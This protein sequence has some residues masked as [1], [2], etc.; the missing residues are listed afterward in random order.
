MSCLKRV[1]SIKHCSWKQDNT[2]SAVGG[3]RKLSWN[4]QKYKLGNQAFC[5]SLPLWFLQWETWR[6][7]R[8]YSHLGI[9]ESSRLPLVMCQRSG[10][11][12]WMELLKFEENIKRRGEG[13]LDPRKDPEAKQ[14]EVLWKEIFLFK[15]KPKYAFTFK[16]LLWIILI[17]S[18]IFF[19]LLQTIM[20]NKY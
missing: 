13:N 10:R 3:I 18:R 4:K 16:F 1:A 7:E 17:N 8:L 2:M 5:I 9:R 6:L 20:S 15:Y 12:K 14:W 11:A 19:S